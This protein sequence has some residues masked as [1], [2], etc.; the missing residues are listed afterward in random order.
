MTKDQLESLDWPLQVSLVCGLGA[1]P[2]VCFALFSSKGLR[3]D[4]SNH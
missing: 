3:L 1:L 2:N 4:F